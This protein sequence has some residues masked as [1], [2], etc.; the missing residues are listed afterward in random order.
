MMDLIDWVIEKIKRFVLGSQ[1]R[2]VVDKL[3]L[4]A[5]IPKPVEAE[6]LEIEKNLRVVKNPSVMKLAR[7]TFTDKSTIGELQFDDV[8]ECYTLEDTVRDKKIAKIT[9]IPAGRYEVIIN[10][11]NRF[12][13][14][15]PLLMNVPNFRG[16][17]IH[18]GNTPKHTEGCL[19][20]GKTK[21]ANFVGNSRQAYKQVYALIEAALAQGKVFIEIINDRGDA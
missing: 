12:Q 15:M 3:D 18:P 14:N 20:V 13:K 6:E 5:E 4:R 17:R 9:A 8:F 2:R 16:I 7:S 10:F 1:R 21:A 11:S 19:L